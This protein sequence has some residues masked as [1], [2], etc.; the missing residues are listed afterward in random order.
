M[1]YLLALQMGNTG[2]RSAAVP[3]RILRK[4]KYLASICI[5]LLQNA[6][7]KV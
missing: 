5:I 4:E 6:A 2:Q 1:V 3:A 7:L